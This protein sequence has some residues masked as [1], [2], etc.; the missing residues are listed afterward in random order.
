M[1]KCP[2][3]IEEGVHESADC[4]HGDALLGDSTPHGGGLPQPAPS[5]LRGGS[6][7]SV[8]ASGAPSGLGWDRRLVFTAVALVLIASFIVSA[9]LGCAF[10]LVASSEMFR[11][12]F[13]V[14]EPPFNLENPDGERA[15]E[16]FSRSVT[17]SAWEQLRAAP[18]NVQSE[19]IK[20][21]ERELLTLLEASGSTRDFCNRYM[22]MPTPPAP[23]ERWREVRRACDSFLE[24]DGELATAQRE[25]AAIEYRRS[26]IKRRLEEAYGN[27]AKAE[28]AAGVVSQGLYVLSGFIVGLDHPRYEVG[29]ILLVNPNGF[30]CITSIKCIVTGYLSVVARGGVGERALLTVQDTVITSEGAFRMLVY[31]KD[32][33]LVDLKTGGVAQ[34]SSF[35]E[36]SPEAWN[37]ARQKVLDC[38]LEILTIE[39]ELQNLEKPRDLS[40]LEERVEHLRSSLVSV[41]DA[42]SQKVGLNADGVESGEGMDSPASGDEEVSEP[43]PVTYRR[44]KVAS[45][46]SK[47]T[48]R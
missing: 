19:W 31:K 7:E 37:R 40:T 38:Q 5:L 39:R 29:D 35:E 48:T 26:E 41:L 44:C 13:F 21:V 28:I 4:P 33:E 17:S 8:E 36:A 27:H 3:C 23:T 20:V 6:E 45:W 43:I 24:G 46:T 25:N 22:E 2:R 18:A 14:Q 34:W 47:M 1:S 15:R 9:M 11:G 12:D 10:L 16:L 30:S 42:T 32:D